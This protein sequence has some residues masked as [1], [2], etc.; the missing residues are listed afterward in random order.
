MLSGIRILIADDHPMV[1]SGLQR[2]LAAEGARA[3]AVH[4]LPAL[5]ARLYEEV[6]DVVV[7]DV[8]FGRES[9]LASLPKLR[10]RFPDVA[11]VIITA[12]GESLR[13]AAMQA[14]AAAFVSKTASPG[15]LVAAVHA[16]TR[17]DAASDADGREAEVAEADAALLRNDPLGPTARQ[18]EILALLLTGATQQDVADELGIGRRTVEFHLKALRQRTGIRRM[19]LLLQWARSRGI[20]SAGDTP[21]G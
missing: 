5:W 11:F 13:A 1:A 3:G 15:D 4:A 9:S 18:A 20:G 12:H 17:R 16:V 2:L 8:A 10:E 7:L 19:S 21:E 14:G 6:A